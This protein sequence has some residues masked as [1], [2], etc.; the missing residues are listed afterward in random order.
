MAVARASPGSWTGVLPVPG[1]MLPQDHTLPPV[2]MARLAVS[3]AA[4]ATAWRGPPVDSFPWTGVGCGAGVVA[5]SGGLAVPSPSWPW[6][7]AP[8]AHTL[9]DASRARLCWPPAATATNVAA[10]G[11]GNLTGTGC[12]LDAGVGPSPSCPPS[13]LPQAYTVPVRCPAT[14]L[15]GQ[16]MAIVCAMKVAAPPTSPR[17]PALSA[18]IAPGSDTAAG[19]WR[20]AVAPVPSWPNWPPPQPTRPLSV[21]AAAGLEAAAGVAATWPLATAG[22]AVTGAGSAATEARSPPIAPFTAARCQEPLSNCRIVRPPAATA[23]PCAG[24]ETPTGPSLPAG[25]RLGDP[26]PA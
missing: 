12:A 24:H 13:F 19:A 23:R 17:P 21:A 16:A 14:S 11:A 15:H 26:R 22:A 7:S 25:T 4:I 8:Q 20:L 18:R 3:P 9:C 6:S 2:S 1:K 5:S 10:I